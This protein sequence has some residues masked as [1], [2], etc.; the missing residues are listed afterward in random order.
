M[1]SSKHTA[2]PAANPGTATSPPL[3]SFLRLWAQTTTTSP[4]KISQ[5]INAPQVYSLPAAVLAARLEA[6]MASGRG[7]DKFSLTGFALKSVLGAFNKF[8]SL[9]SPIGH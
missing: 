6:V 7:A 4:T 1:S 9:G 8:P 2:P 5:A 3:S